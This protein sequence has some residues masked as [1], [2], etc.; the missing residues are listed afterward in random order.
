MQGRDEHPAGESALPVLPVGR[1]FERKCKKKRLLDVKWHT[2]AVPTFSSVDANYSRTGACARSTL[3]SSSHVV[4]RFTSRLPEKSAHARFMLL[5]YVE[6]AA[7]VSIFVKALPL[8]HAKIRSHKYRC[9]SPT[10]L[11]VSTVVEAMT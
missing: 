3:S 4:L 2:L 7:R 5:L 1:R 10:F 8:L 6:C 9:G 11:F